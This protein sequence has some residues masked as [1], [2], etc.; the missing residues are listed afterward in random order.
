MTQRRFSC[1]RSRGG[2]ASPLVTF[3]I[4]WKRQE[5]KRKAKAVG[6]QRVLRKAGKWRLHAAMNLFCFEEAVGLLVLT[7]GGRQLM[8]WVH[9]QD[10]TIPAPCFCRPHQPRTG[11]WEA[12][13]RSRAAC[14]NPFHPLSMLLP[15]KN[16]GTHQE[17][18]GCTHGC[19]LRLN[20]VI[21]ALAD[22]WLRSRHFVPTCEITSTF[23]CAFLL[24]PRSPTCSSWFLR[25]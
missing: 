23:G 15:L 13:G 6:P 9:R 24:T 21:R 17:L 22:L 2:Q 14:K 20:T 11:C 7:R 4:G 16:V 3:R 8:F 12:W 25:S 1:I 18:E 5:P 19:Y 10:S